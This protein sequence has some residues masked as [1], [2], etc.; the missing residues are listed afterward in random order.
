[1]LVVKNDKALALCRKSIDLKIT[2][3]YNKQKTKG[4]VTVDYLGK[5][6][7]HYRPSSGWIND[8]NGLVYF[9]GYYHV[10]YQNSPNFERPWHEHMHWGHARTK[11]FLNW[12]QLPT[13]LTPEEDYDI[14]GCWSGTAIVKDDTLYLF[15]ASISYPKGHD[16]ILETVSVAYSTDGINFTKYEGNPV[17]AEHP[18]DGGPD[19]RDPAVCCVDGKYYCVMASGNAES[20]TARLLLYKSEDLLNWEYVGVMCEWAESKFAECPSFMQTEYGFLL[21]ASVCPI[22]GD[23]YFSVM[24]G[25]FENDVFTIKHSAS[26]DR[27]PDQYAGQVFKDHLGRA[28]LITW[29]PGWRYQ[30]YAERDIGCMSV[31]REI[32]LKDGV[33]YG[34][35]AKEVQHL[36]VDEDPCVRRTKTGFVIERTGRDSVV[37]EGEIRD[38]KIL[39]DEYIV[40]VFVNGGTDIYTALL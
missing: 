38:F 34:Y 3:W 26:L 20:R 33:I 4:D 31:P 18:A 39:R 22:E 29:T 16:R 24:F 5:L 28:L 19:F 9:D 21:T 37:Y 40:E 1:M 13:A 7:Y 32:T 10:F 23:P 11:D 36:L 2:R 8:P 15:Y 14:K 17:I 6:K 30:G 35:P 12:E 27:G 25:D